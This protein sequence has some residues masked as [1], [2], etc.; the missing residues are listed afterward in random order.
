VI[1]H[2]ALVLLSVL[3]SKGLSDF[4]SWVYIL[5]L[6]V[7]SLAVAVR[8]LHDTGRSAWWM[9]IL[10]ISF[11][12]IIGILVAIFLFLF[13]MCL[14]SQPGSNKYGSNPKF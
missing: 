3:L 1:F 6:L 5:A 14:D 12:P 9:L 11:I 8:R 4:I 2:V 7:P 10:L 13:L